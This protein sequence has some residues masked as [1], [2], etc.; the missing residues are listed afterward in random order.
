MITVVVPPG[1]V[2]TVVVVVE[3][4]FGIVCCEEDR[5]LGAGG[6]VGG[7]APF[8]DED[9]FDGGGGA[10]ADDVMLFV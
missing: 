6:G 1:P 8:K 2:S 10:R 7:L 5:G 9:E 3:L 4:V